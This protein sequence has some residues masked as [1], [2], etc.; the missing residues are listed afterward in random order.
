MLDTLLQIGLFDLTLN[1][2]ISLIKLSKTH[3]FYK[4]QIIVTFYLLIFFEYL[5]K[6]DLSVYLISNKEKSRFES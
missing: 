1:L 6:K 5:V 2:I 3:Q 4:I